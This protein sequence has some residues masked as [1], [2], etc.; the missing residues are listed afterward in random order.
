VLL[1]DNYTVHVT[2]LYTSTTA[3]NQLAPRQKSYRGWHPG[4]NWPGSELV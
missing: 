3:D 1:T 2:Q 4:K